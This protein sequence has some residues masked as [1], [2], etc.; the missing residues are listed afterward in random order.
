MKIFFTTAI[1]LISTSVFAACSIED[2]ATS[3][4]IAGIQQPQPMQRTYLPA[5][6]IKEYSGT[7]EA[8]LIPSQNN[9]PSKQLR[10]FGPQPVD[11][12]Y[13]TSCQFGVCNP[14]GVPQL[15]ERR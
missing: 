1:L 12:S 11:Y 13:N 7:P 8:R 14:S 3:C 10:D 9:L 6:T 15:F 5:S 4:S 2:G